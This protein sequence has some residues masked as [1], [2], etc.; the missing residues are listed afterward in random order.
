M[1][2]RG[3]GEKKKGDAKGTHQKTRTKKKSR[4][5]WR[6]W[7]EDQTGFMARRRSAHWKRKEQEWHAI[8][9][10]T[11]DYTYKKKT[12]GPFLP[13][14][15]SLKQLVVHLLLSGTTFHLMLFHGPLKQPFF[16]LSN[17]LSSLLFIRATGAST[18]RSR[19]VRKR[20]QQKKK[21][22]RGKPASDS[23]G[24]SSAGHGSCPHQRLI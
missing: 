23:E 20:E 19:G 12:Q 10:K 8:R 2:N 15:F 24:E 5:Q 7:K 21:D 1:E 9:S 17:H 6:V 22:Q 18:S 11:Y 3:R 16:S 13:L 4:K 14:F